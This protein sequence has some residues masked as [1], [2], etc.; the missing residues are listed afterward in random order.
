MVFVGVG[1]LD[2]DDLC[3][4]VENTFTS[5]LP[6]SPVPITAQPAI[7]TGS[8]YR[9]RIDSLEDVNFAYAFPTKGVKDPHFFTFGV[10]GALLGNYQFGAAHSEYAPSELISQISQGNLAKSVKSVNMAYSD[11]GLFGVYAV[12]HPYKVNSLSTVIAKEI[13]NL[14]Y[15]VDKSY[16][17]W[18][19][20]AFLSDILSQYRTSGTADI[21]GNDL[22]LH[23][24]VIHPV[25]IA[26]RIEAITPNDVMS[27]AEATFYDTDFALA[28]F[29]N[30]WE[31]PDYQ[32]FRS[33]TYKKHF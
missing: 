3:K 4:T 1:D 29:G 9:H 19:K 21:L 17:E 7:F 20:K 12:A 13:T 28:A 24:R 2:H 27:A 16:F 30:V 14:I 22:L 11:V 10:I 6:T 15:D 23:G 25:E 18:A 5:I 32:Y 8:D 33:R 31:L 26:K